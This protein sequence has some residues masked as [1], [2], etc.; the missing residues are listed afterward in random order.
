MTAAVADQIMELSI[1]EADQLA[2]RW[3]RYA[4]P[5]WEDRP[6]VWRQLLLAAQAHDPRAMREAS[7]RGLQLITG[8]LI[9][10]SKP[11]KA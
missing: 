11:R 1:A 7:S 4:R 6:G 5:R 10:V 3:Y 9:D 8:A 2:A